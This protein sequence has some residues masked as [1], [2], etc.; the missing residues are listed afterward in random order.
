L[1]TNQ[2][3]FT[4]NTPEAVMM[5]H[6]L[7]TAP[8]L[9]A[10]YPEAPAT[11]EPVIRKALEKQPEDRYATAEA[12]LA[13]FRAAVSGSLRQPAQPQSPSASPVAP[14]PPMNDPAPVV[15]TT[16][17]VPL[18]KAQ[19]TA[20]LCEVDNCGV[21]AV[22]RCATCGRAF[23]ASHKNLYYNSP[24]LANYYPPADYGHMC[25]PCFEVKHAKAVELHAEA[26]APFKYFES[27]AAR[28]DLLTSG[29]QPVNLYHVAL[30]QWERKK[31]FF[32]GG[33]RY[34]DVVTLSGRGWILGEFEWRDLGGNYL[35]AL[36]NESPNKG[37][38]DYGLVRV[39]PYTGGYQDLSSGH[40]NHFQG[41]WQ[42][43]YGWKEVMQAVKQLTK[44]SS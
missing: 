9:H 27:G 32:G 20:A 5:K 13:D 8:P 38:T 25:A 39:Q 35:T 10:A 26:Q 16:I 4:G 44:A 2:R 17:P 3:P 28:T 1:L 29:V 15:Q 41:N 34:V 24:P 31:G 19:A 7:E 37:D 12:L 43:G 14:T 42:T 33:G 21:L 40:N 11:L 22:G 36:V 30:Q 6:L 23:C 18:N